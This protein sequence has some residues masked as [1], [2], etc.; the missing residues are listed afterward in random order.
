MVIGSS[1]KDGKTVCTIVVISEETSF[2]AARS[3]RQPVDYT[4]RGPEHLARFLPV[5]R[6]YFMPTRLYLFN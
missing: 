1:R 6:Q 5:L 2:A 4:R 3:K